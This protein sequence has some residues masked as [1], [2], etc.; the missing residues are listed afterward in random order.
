MLKRES[1]SGADST[2]S[3][4]KLLALSQLSETASDASSDVSSSVGSSASTANIKALIQE[5]L[6]GQG[7]GGGGVSGG[8]TGGGSADGHSITIPHGTVCQFC[9]AHAIELVLALKV[10]LFC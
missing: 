8:G 6:R 7:G 1:R 4:S 9:K 5:A 3:L 10:L 2:S